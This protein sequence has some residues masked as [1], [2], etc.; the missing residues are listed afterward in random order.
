MTIFYSKETKGFYMSDIHSVIPEDVTPI[1]KELYDSLIEGMSQG[2]EIVTDAF[3]IP[4]LADRFVPLE[5]KIAEY[6]TSI[7]TFIDEKAKS[8]GYTNIYTAISFRGDPNLKFNN[9]AE[10]LF[11][12]RSAVWTHVNTLLQAELAELAVNPQ[13]AL[14]TPSEVLSGLPEFVAPTY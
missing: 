4:S 1:S 6:D 8:L 7:T 12:W 2:K 3:N 11:V 5:A 14:P 13:H 10:A 9:E